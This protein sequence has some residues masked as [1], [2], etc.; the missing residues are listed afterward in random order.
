MRVSALVN[1][2]EHWNRP[3]YPKLL[4][5]D[6]IPL[7]P[8]H[9]NGA[10]QAPVRGLTSGRRRPITA[11]TKLGDSPGW[12]S[13]G[14]SCGVSRPSGQGRGLGGNRR[15]KRSPALRRTVARPRKKTGPAQRDTRE[16]V[17]RVP[18]TLRQPPQPPIPPG[19]LGVHP[20]P[21]C[22]LKP[23]T[24]IHEHVSCR[25]ATGHEATRQG[26]ATVAH[27]LESWRCGCSKRNPKPGHPPLNWN[28]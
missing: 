26:V 10:V 12:R 14:H 9:V 11:S 2:E 27:R 22:R 17:E 4:T 8:A 6:L 3:R 16:A 15:W 23:L 19:R 1:E 28:A 7:G 20:R 18:E 13:S 21:R 24:L 25:V 5:S